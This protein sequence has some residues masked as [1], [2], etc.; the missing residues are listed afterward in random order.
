MLF[1]VSLENDHIYY[2]HC[3]ILSRSWIFVIKYIGEK[4]IATYENEI[5]KIYLKKKQHIQTNTDVSIASTLTNT[6]CIT[7]RT[8]TWYSGRLSIS[9]KCSKSEHVYKQCKS[10]FAINRNMCNVFKKRP[11]LGARKQ[12][13]LKL[14][15]HLSWKEAKL[16]KLV[17]YI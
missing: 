17:T 14:Y 2:N 11:L 15:S 8:Y 5:S 13:R 9:Y 1:F 3:I 7:M 4:I 12:K 16:S 6:H 10:I